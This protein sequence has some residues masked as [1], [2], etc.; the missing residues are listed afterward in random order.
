MYELMRLEG[1]GRL[2]SLV[3]AIGL[4]F[5]YRAYLSPKRWFVALERLNG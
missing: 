1:N 2:R 3:K 5:G 4:K